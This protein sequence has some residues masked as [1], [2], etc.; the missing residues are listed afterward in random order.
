[1]PIEKVLIANRGEIA[2]RILRTLRE[3]GI[4]SVAVFSDADRDELHVR[5]A[6]E[7][8]RLGPPAPSASYLRIDRIL[9]VARACGADAV[10]PGYGFLSENAG[11]ARAVEEAGLTFIGPSPASIA[12]AG[13][14]LAARSAMIAAGVPVIPG[15][16]EPIGDAGEIE[17][18]AKEI[19]F[20]VALKAVGGGGG[21]GIRVVREAAGLKEAFARASAEAEAAF[22]NGAMYVEKFLENPRHIEIQ[23]LS[24]T[25]GNH[26]HLGERECSIQRRHQ[27]LLEEAPSP[28]VDAAMRARMGAAAT[29]AAAA[30]DYR[31]AGT[32][33]FLADRQGEFYF[34]EMNTRIQVEH[35]VTEL[36]YGIDLIR[37]QVRIAEG[38]TLPFR[39]EELQP[40]GHAIEIRLTAEDPAQGFFPQT[41]VVRALRMPEG[42]G[43][44]VD[45]NLYPGQEIT[46]HYDPMIGKI[47]AHGRDRGNAIER[48]KRALVEMRL[49]GLKTCAP[50]LLRL[51]DDPAFRRGDTDTGYLER[52]VADAAWQERPDLNDLPADLP[53]LITA[54]LY[55][56]ERQGASGAVVARAAQ[57]RGSAWLEA[58]RRESLR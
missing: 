24:D 29:K 43:V 58:G 6:D 32:V 7:A 35:P 25:H 51:L 5:Q 9:E 44:R 4:R 17:A 38:E 10:H 41:G 20:P 3:M 46:L 2:L 49:V 28:N 37:W 23:V 42:P 22:G 14:K 21:K 40:Q 13:D 36:V 48:L 11:F 33:E 56:H 16:Q 26:L 54:V 1:M 30:V 47:I 53:A 18:I 52:Y 19:G 12:A 45:A 27:K 55:A 39:Q 57:D 31:G 8:Y 34:L 15:S 50:L